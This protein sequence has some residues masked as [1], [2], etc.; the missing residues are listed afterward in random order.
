MIPYR[1]LTVT[2]KYSKNRLIR[3]HEKLMKDALSRSPS[4]IATMREHI[5][6]NADIIKQVLYSLERKDGLE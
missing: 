3:A 4:A 1:R 5:S 6:A 2:D